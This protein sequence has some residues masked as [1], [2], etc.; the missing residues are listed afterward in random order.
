MRLSTLRDI[1]K[2]KGKRVLLRLDLNIPLDARGRIEASGEARLRAAI[3]TLKHLMKAGARVV[4]VS[5]LGRPAGHD[6]ALSLA[7]VARRL[8]VLMGA[9]MWFI[10][11]AI[12]D[13]D[14]IEKR[15]AKM[16]DGEAAM[17]ENIRFTKGED[18]DNIFLARRLASFADIFVNEAFSA[19]HRAS[20][21]IVGVAR[22]LPSYAGLQLER[23]VAALSKVID[24][25][26][27][28]LVVMLGGAKVSGKIHVIEQMVKIADKVL[29]GG[30]MANAFL[31]AK[32][33]HVGKSL[34]SITDV[35]L[36]KKLLK[37]TNI[38]LPTD[39]LTS[40]SLKGDIEPH[41][42]QNID[43]HKDDFIVDIGTE[44][45]RRWA[46]ILKEAKTLVWNGP[47]GLFEVKQFSHGSVALG[48]VL[49]ARSSGKAYGVV[50]GGETVECLE[51]TGMAE[52][53]DHVSTGGGA[54]LDFLA[55]KKLPGLVRLLKK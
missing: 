17:L 46:G 51:R 53:V 23:E 11:D 4:I 55:G 44:T 13:S 16:N 32:G 27:K 3:P 19:C 31:K 35:K 28:P 15:L 9:D 7:P 40:R 24:K 18:S 42:R 29:I 10:P 37:K 34:V 38:L 6:K 8:S 49:A 26:K 5:H 25:P 48:R 45:A 39:V 41:V 36:A 22:L 43:V 47:V 12:E 33:F 1:K 14:K 21:S 50:G 54:M 2:L 20:A 30:A 52:F